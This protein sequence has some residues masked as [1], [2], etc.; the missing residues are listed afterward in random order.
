SPLA[1][2]DG[3]ALALLLA[4]TSASCVTIDIVATVIA[5][6]PAGMNFGDVP[7][8]AM[9]SLLAGVLGLL[10]FPVLAIACATLLADRWLGTSF[11]PSEGGADPTLWPRLT[12]LLGHPQIALLLMPAMGAATEVVVTA[13]GRPLHGRVLV[14]GVGLTLAAAGALAWLAQWTPA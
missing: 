14:R 7:P 13:A 9:N 12:A 1:G 4:S 3:W 5:R 8:F 11:H 2:V 6:R 10:A